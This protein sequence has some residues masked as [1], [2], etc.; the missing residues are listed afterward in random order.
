MIRL[1]LTVAW[2][3]ARVGAS[4]ART[5]APSPMTVRRIDLL[6]GGSPVRGAA[7]RALALPLRLPRDPRIEVVP[8]VDPLLPQ[9]EAHQHL[10]DAAVHVEGGR[11]AGI[12]ERVHLDDVDPHHGVLGRQPSEEREQLSRGKAAGLGG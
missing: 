8:G 2:A 1:I 10:A 5:R 9:G 11:V 12:D 4:T 7:E 6:P 3:L